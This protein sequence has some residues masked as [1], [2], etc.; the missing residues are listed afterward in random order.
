MPV[1]QSYVNMNYGEMYKAWS[2]RFAGL[3]TETELRDIH[4]RFRKLG[5]QVASGS[6]ITR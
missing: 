5:K 1:H 3:Y 6:R 2:E 4:R